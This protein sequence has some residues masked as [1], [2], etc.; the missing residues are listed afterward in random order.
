[1][2]ASEERRYSEGDELEAHRLSADAVAALVRALR[3]A[4]PD[5][6]EIRLAR[7]KLRHF[8]DERPVHVVGFRVRT[9]WYRQTSSV[10]RKALQRLV[11]VPLEHPVH[12]IALD[13]SRAAASRFAAVRDSMVFSR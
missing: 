2:E 4:E 11:A 10:S 13:V 5:L 8:R 1:M 3:A 12:L 7:K 6:E 9:P